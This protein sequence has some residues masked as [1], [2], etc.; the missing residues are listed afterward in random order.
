M[1]DVILQYPSDNVAG[2]YSTVGVNSG[3]EDLDYPA[4][5]LADGRPGR[6]A[7]LTTTSGSWVFDFGSAQR[8]DLVV[9][10]AHNLSAVS[11]EGN[12]SNVW[13]SPAFSADLV[14]P[15]R[16]ADGHSVNAW[17]DLTTESGYSASGF[18]YWRL[19]VSGSDPCAVGELWLG[20]TIRTTDR[21][22]ALGFTISETPATI[23]HRTEFLIPLVY[24]LGSRERRLALTFRARSAGA[25]A[26]REWY[27]SMQGPGLTSIFIPDV[28][29][30]DAWWIRH[31][32]D[33]SE[34][35]PYAEAR[36]VSMNLTEHATGVPL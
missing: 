23:A 28:N 36:D 34:A 1:S 15:T 35:V 2:L 33:Y 10:G 22:Y 19:V 29:V 7:K 18:Q 25:V 14:I 17:V 30:N 4:S 31:A 9:L 8:I 12:A 5:Y 26:L 6:P 20:Q 11:I 13:T 32:G 16:T 21:G 24:A 27:R 3:S